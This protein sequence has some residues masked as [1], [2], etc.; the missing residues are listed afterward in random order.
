MKENEKADE[1]YENG[2]RNTIEFYS[3]TLYFSIVHKF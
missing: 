3:N 2:S 1:Q